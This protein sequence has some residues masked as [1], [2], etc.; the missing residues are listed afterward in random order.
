VTDH[1]TFRYPLYHMPEHTP[2]K[3]DYLKL[4]RVVVGLQGVVADLAR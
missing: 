2:D 3:L 1:A 4:A